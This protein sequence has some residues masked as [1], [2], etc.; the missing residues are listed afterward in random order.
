MRSSR[1]APPISASSRRERRTQEAVGS[2]Q[3]HARPSIPAIWLAATRPKT[4]G[5]SLCPVTMGAALAWHD[6]VFAWAPVLA[7]FA[8]ACLLQVAS[9]FANDLFDGLRGTDSR[10]RLG[11]AR[12]VASGWVSPLAMGVALAIVLTLAS[13]PAFYLAE[14]A[15]HVFALIGVA[16][17]VSAVF[18]TAP[19]FMLGYRGLGDVF[20]FGFFGPLA[21]AG[22]RAACDG[23]WT[24]EALLLGLAPGAIAVALL[25]VNNLRDR[26]GDAA[27]GK[28][29]LAV[30][31]GERF[32]RTQIAACHAVAMGVPV[33]AAVLYGL[34]WTIS[35]ASLVAILF[36]PASES[37]RRGRD[38]AAL[39]ANLVQ[40]GAMLVLYGLAFLA[41]IAAFELFLRGAA[42]GAA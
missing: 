23:A 34:P 41:G 31:Y 17:A 13:A 18:Y 4:L 39:N 42:G 29:T 32:A 27:S 15:G 9:N 12:A 16:G 25:A 5:A 36:L 28:R 2:V 22:T 37:I 33:F 40:F 11:P 21:V 35:L 20:V 3:V 30:R 6:G 38:G 8:G 14:R 24:E 10:E 7:A 26:A 19:P 1:S